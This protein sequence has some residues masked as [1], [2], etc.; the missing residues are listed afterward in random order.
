MDRAYI[1]ELSRRIGLPQR[2]KEAL[3]AYLEQHSMAVDSMAQQ[4]CKKGEGWLTLLQGELWRRK[5]QEDR[6]LFALAVVLVMTQETK[7]CYQSLGIP[8]EFFYHT[9]QD[10][11][12][13]SETCERNYHV[14]GL[15]N[16]AWLQNHLLPNLFRIGRL[17]FQF[18]KMR[19]PLYTRPKRK[20]GLALRQG[21][22]CIYIH[23]PEGEPLTRDACVQSIDA[24]RDFFFHYFPDYQYRYYICE[25]WLLD[26]QNHNVLPE[27]ANILQF[28][29]LFQ[30]VSSFRDD[31][32]AME[33]IFGK[34]KMD[35]DDY[36]GDTLLQRNVKE[37]IKNRGKMGIGFGV[38]PK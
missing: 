36:P 13:W 23:I 17:Q 6:Y 4:L 10:I 30:I 38:I 12:I 27:D 33:R 16:L 5:R 11:T 35:V 2:T 31:K 9:M 15:E 21:E 18:A 32:Q 7:K 28:A 34:E 29:S 37:Y 20:K 3:D 22:P 24:S 8:D 14:P 25:S 19:Y 26:P 1:E